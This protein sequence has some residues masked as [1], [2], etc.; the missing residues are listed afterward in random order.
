MNVALIGATG[1]GGSCILTELIERGHQVTAIVR[2]AEKVPALPGVTAQQGDACDGD[3]LR[4]L[5]AGHDAVISAV[6]FVPTDSETLIAAVRDSGVP[7]FIVMGGAAGLETAP[8]VKLIDSPHFPPEYR[9]E[10]TKA[11]AFLKLL[12]QEPDLDWTFVSPAALIEHGE[13]TTTFRI[14]GDQLLTDA[15]GNSRITFEDYAIA[16]VDELESHAHP[17]QRISVAY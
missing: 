1:R 12:K 17:R 7:R 13:R 8:G 2:H 14:G 6:Q 4:T 10:A 15:D 5:I 3:A 16:L 11:I 9:A